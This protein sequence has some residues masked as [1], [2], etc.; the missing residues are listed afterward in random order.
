MSAGGSVVVGVRK[1]A[2][3]GNELRRP[4]IRPASPG[5]SLASAVNRGRSC[6]G[7]RLSARVAAPAD[8]A[9]GRR[10]VVLVVEA[11]LGTTDATA[12]GAR[13]GQRDLASVSSAAEVGVLRRPKRI[14]QVARRFLLRSDLGAS[15][16]AQLLPLAP[17]AIAVRLLRLIAQRFPALLP[18]LARSTTFGHRP[19]RHLDPRRQGLAAAQ[20]SGGKNPKGV[21]FP[22]V[23]L[24]APGPFVALLLRMLRMGVAL[25]EPAAA[26]RCLMRSRLPWQP[27]PRPRRAAAGTPSN[28]C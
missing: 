2:G 28:T 20:H 17:A 5:S 23:A 14:A 3:V 9:P 12:A 19:S 27:A 15:L 16:V 6:I 4:A 7:G 18:Q 11:N 13:L 26:L 22:V 21:F 8:D 1:G 10:L 24:S 25:P